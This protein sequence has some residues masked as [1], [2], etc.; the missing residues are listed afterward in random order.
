MTRRVVVAF[1]GSLDSAAAFAALGARIGAD[2]STVTLDLGQGAELAQVRDQAIAAGAVRA[3]VV[4]ARQELAAEVIRPA[5]VA[6]AFDGCAHATSVTRPVI[7]RHLVA[8]ARMEGADAV[9]HG[10]RGE[11]RVRLERL[12]AALA[13]ELAIHALADEDVA[14]AEHGTTQHLWARVVTGAACADRLEAMYARTSAPA[15]LASVPAVVAVSLDRGVPVAVSGVTLDLDALIE[16]IDTIAGDHGVGRFEA[17]EDGVYSLVEAPAAV[18]L[19]AAVQ[20]LAS[21]A[22][23]A[24]L[25]AVRAH[26]ARAYGALIT[27]GGWHDHTRAALDAFSTAVADRLTGTVTLELSGGEC[28][29]L[30]SSVPQIATAAVAYS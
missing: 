4:D 6:G 12:V 30:D 11:D 18:V 3:H 8:V 27:D 29:V 23:P 25:A 17:T 10:A 9:A 16:V 1:G 5:L 7:A 26:V 24:D 13:P 20:A 21:R 2:V 22:L 19:G 15:A 28:R 14:T